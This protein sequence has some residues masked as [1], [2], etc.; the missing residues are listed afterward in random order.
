M[1]DKN[2]NFE[3]IKQALLG[4]QENI[5][6]VLR[7]INEMYDNEENDASEERIEELKQEVNL[8][9]SQLRGA[10]GKT[11]EGIFDGQSM[12]GPDG[13]QYSVPA[14]YAS[15]SKLIEGDI[16]KLSISSTGGFI[17]K[18]IG[19]AERDRIVAKLAKNE[20][21]YYAE[22][23]GR[24]WK[25]LSASVTYYKGNEGDEVVILVPKGKSARW[26]AVENIVKAS[27]N[28]NNVNQEVEG[29]EFLGRE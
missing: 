9:G 7:L 15:K 17:Y 24:K 25:L 1:E 6:K 4:I 26:A 5:S 10:D 16:L 3:I 29:I 22:I 28:F 20:N 21:E 23:D 8:I 18:Q 13:K 14:N 12:I 19:P 11:V 2:K 27:N